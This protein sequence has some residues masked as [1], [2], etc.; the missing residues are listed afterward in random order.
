M[1]V[2][3][4]GVVNTRSVFGIEYVKSDVGELFSVT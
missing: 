3:F 4:A 1:T 2:K